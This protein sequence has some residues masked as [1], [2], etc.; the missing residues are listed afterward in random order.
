MILSDDDSVKF[1]TGLPCKASL[2]TVFDVIM[3]RT[4]AVNYWR[5][6]N[7]GSSSE[8]PAGPGGCMETIDQFDEYLLTLVYIRQGITGRFLSDLFGVSPSTVTSITNRWVSVLYQVMKN[9]LVW[10]STEQVKSTFPK[11]YP[12]KYADTRVI[13]DCTEFFVHKPTNCTTHSQYKH[14]NTVKVMIG[15]TP[16]GMISF[17]SQ[18][19]GASTSDRYIA[20]NEILHLIEPGNTVIADR[21]FNICDLLLQRGAKLHTPPFTQEIAEGEARTLTQSEIVESREIAC[22]R[23]H[24]ERAVERINK[25]KILSNTINS[26][27]WPLLHQIL[28]VVA[29]ICNLQPPLLK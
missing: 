21:G 9:W 15:T 11:K 10:P 16:R 18:P 29:V 22:L 23:I 20:E 5:G 4:T 3:E 2:I 1:Y 25:F 8:L 24:V 12:A 13:L 26:H 7:S 14:H 19:Y 6:P 27:V 28:V 17:V